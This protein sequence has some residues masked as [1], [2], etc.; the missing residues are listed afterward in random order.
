MTTRK[1]QTSWR[2]EFGARPT[3]GGILFRVWA[4]KIQRLAVRIIGDTQY[5]MEREDDEIFRALVP[6]RAAGTDYLYIIDDSK[7]RPDPV[8]RLQ[9]EGVHSPSRV[10]DPD[11]F[12]WTDA[13]WK[14]LA[15]DEYVIYELHV[16]TFTRAGSF[17][18][19][20]EKLEYLRNVGITAVELMPVGAFPGDRNWGYDSVYAYA[21][22]SVY[23]GPDGLKKLVDAC[24]RR[25]LAVI[26]DVVYNHLGPEGNYLSDFGPYFTRHYLTPWGDALNFDGAYSDG[27]RRYFIENALHWLVEYHIDALRLDAVHGIFDFGARHVLEE[28]GEKFHA[29][30][31]SLGRRAYLIAESDLND[32]RVINPVEAGGYGLDAQWNDDFHH[33]LNAILTGT[34]R[35]YLA[36]FG[37]IADLRKA[38]TDSFVFD[39]R[40]SAYRHRH[41]GNSSARQP[42]DR[43]V[44]FTQN[45]DQVANAAAGTRLSQLITP[46]AQKLA[47]MVLV[48]APNLPMLFMGQEFS[49]STPFFYF[50]SFVDAALAKAVSEG[51]K[52][53]Y[54]GFLHDQPFADPQEFETF[55]RSRLNWEEPSQPEHSAILDFY[56][57]LFAL[58]RKHPCLSNCRKDLATVECNEAQGWLSITRDD[59]SGSGALVLCNFRD[60]VR[61]IAVP[62][63][64]RAWRLALWNGEA[65]F[66]NQADDPAPPATLD[67]HGR[68]VK[69]SGFGAALYLTE[70]AE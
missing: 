31:N 26:M 46:M 43:F 39:G 21:P 19:A 67:G 1:S 24:H 25:G 11:A 12:A 63:R 14:G 33:S 48:C 36:D 44:V 41:H 53:E 50:T 68:V 42:G 62:D 22:H 10:I 40:Y 28:L 5:A 30:A 8:S 20:I 51:R 38:L 59:P 52:R 7:E 60:D 49:A 23:G 6:D 32:V 4:P 2:L 47:A 45:H 13:G 15:L 70:S 56:R 9:P 34:R 66:G 57:S 35:G 18:A 65:R 54:E 58:R 64:G 16:G 17:E 3:N 69:L 29:V 61:D 55:A 37:R 27:V